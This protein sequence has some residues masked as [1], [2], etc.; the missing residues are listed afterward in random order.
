MKKLLNE[1]IRYNLFKNKRDGKIYAWIF[2]TNKDSNDLIF[3][4]KDIINQY[5][6][7]FNKAS[8]KW[9]WTLSDDQE[10]MKRQIRSMIIPCIKALSTI[11]NEGNR[12][13]NISDPKIQKF[14]DDI[15]KVLKEP[16]SMD[17]FNGD[18][19]DGVD[20]NDI[21]TRIAAYKEQLISITSDEEFKAVFEPII[22]MRQAMGPGFSLLNSL[23]VYLQDPDATMVK[24]RGN[25][26]KCNRE[27]VK[28]ATPIALY[29]PHGK[30]KYPTQMEKDAVKNDFL[31]KHN[32]KTTAELTVGEREELDRELNSF[33]EVTHFTLEPNWFDHRFTEPMKNKE[34]LAPRASTKDIEW[35]DK[36]A[37]PSEKTTALYDAAIKVITSVGIKIN[38]RTEEEM[39]GARGVSRSDG[40][41]DVIKGNVK[42]IDD[43]G[44]LIH[45]FAHSLLH[46]EY[47]KKSNEEWAKFFIG[48]GSRGSREQQAD[49]TSWIVC[50]YFG[51][52]RPTSINYTTLW[53]MDEKRAP[54]V[55]DTVGEVSSE[56]IRK[57]A[58]NMKT[59]VTESINENSQIISG[60]D[61]ANMLG[62]GNL[63]LKNNKKPKK[64]TESYIRNMIQTIIKEELNKRNG[65]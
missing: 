5:G 25:W 43:F 16:V 1:E 49:L 58:Q 17:D 48:R 29:M 22:K 28:G 6:A 20:I 50:R 23:L 38:Y 45:E 54:K 27:V 9:T 18:V 7:T 34:D 47:V 24:S 37:T 44:T 62:L 11:E 26:K 2:G 3:Q 30:P 36:N 32:V 59:N 14:I 42:N 33:K 39:G 35:W 46:Q 57:L 65:Q 21:K 10:T 56:I 19:V 61:V 53:G 8:K 51:F 64:I 4:N 55:F 60:L 31:K 13:I 63:Y 40:T 15:N 52:D 12:D 41:I